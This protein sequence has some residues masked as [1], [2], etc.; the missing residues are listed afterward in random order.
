MRKP[1]LVE[2]GRYG[3]KL[4]KLPAVSYS[5]CARIPFYVSAKTIAALEDVTGF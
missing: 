4:T 5:L 2:E 3:N 1:G